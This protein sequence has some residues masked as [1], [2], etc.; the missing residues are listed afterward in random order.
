MRYTAGL[1][2]G[3]QRHASRSSHRPAVA[4]AAHV[5]GFRCGE[6]QRGG[7][8]QSLLSCPPPPQPCL[9]LWCLPGQASLPLF[10]PELFPTPR[11]PGHGPNASHLS[12][13]TPVLPANPG[14]AY[15][16]AGTEG[17]ALARPRAREDSARPC[18]SHPH[19][20]HPGLAGGGGQECRRL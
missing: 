4:F 10:H 6:K 11:A 7:S 20:Q 1:A 15:V 5:G 18:P 19:P 12:G 14:C 2:A 9:S 3:G 8:P 13:Q 16:D 17:R